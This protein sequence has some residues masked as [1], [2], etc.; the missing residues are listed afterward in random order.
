[1]DP[2]EYLNQ[3]RFVNQDIETR[4]DERNK[5]RD[6]IAIKTSTLS[7]DKVQ[8][9]GTINFDDKYMIFVEASEEI[10][11]KVDGLIE[12]KMKISNEIDRLEKSEHRVILRSRYINLWSF[13]EIAVKMNYDIRHIHRLHGNALKSFEETHHTMSLYVAHKN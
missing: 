8:E 12:L 4:V 5:L 1:M 7:M 10:N 13:E 2:K 6:S 3:I 11:K 9:S